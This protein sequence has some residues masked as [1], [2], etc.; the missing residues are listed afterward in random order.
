LDFMVNIITIEREY[1]CGG[2][3]IAQF[4]AKTARLETMGPAAD[5]GDRQARE[6][7]QGGG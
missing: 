2:G 3:D 5:G 6:L 1:G 7:P 4:V